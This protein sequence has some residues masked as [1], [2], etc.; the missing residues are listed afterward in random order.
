MARPARHPPHHQPPLP[1]RLLWFI[2][3]WL[4]GVAAVAG[5]ALII[6]LALGH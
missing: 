5:V 4:A 1:Q 6:K 3:L 2:A